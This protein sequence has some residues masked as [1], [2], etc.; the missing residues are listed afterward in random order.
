MK[1]RSK[2]VYINEKLEAKVLE[3]DNDKIISINDYDSDYDTDFGDNLILPG[4]IDIHT[5]GYGGH[6]ASRPTV[7]G[8]NVWSKNMLNEGV[9]SYLATT[10]TQSYDKNIKALKIISDFIEEDN[11]VGAEVIGINVEGNF[12]NEKHRGAQELATIV[13]PDVE[14]LNDYIKASNNHIK[15]VICAVELDDNYEF[16]KYASE[17]GISVSVGHSGANFADVKEALAYGLTGATHTG[18]GMKSLHH[19]EPAVFGAAMR[20]DELYAEVI[21]DGL[22]LHYDIVN[23]I[24]RLKGKDKLVLV[25]DSSSYKD[26][27]AIE[28]GYNRIVSEDGSIRTPEGNLSGS[29]LKFNDGVYNAI[30]YAELDFVTVINASTI[31]PANYLNIG[32]KKGLIKL[33]YDS[34]LIVCDDEFNIIETYVNN[35]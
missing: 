30:K 8:L 21:V 20:L 1:I 27:Q 32:H 17:A 3:F 6:N 13:K 12:I 29:S 31:N 2:R 9:T 28:E 33:G 26:Y 5:H 34:D 23:I 14:V 4:F 16:T 22:H 11:K 18:N 35:R 19:R 15:S 25:T 7:E 10:G 24:G